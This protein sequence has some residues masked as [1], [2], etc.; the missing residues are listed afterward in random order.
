[1]IEA[2]ELESDRLVRRS[3]SDLEAEPAAEEEAGPGEAGV[4]LELPV[5]V[6]HWE[7]VMAHCAFAGIKYI[8]LISRVFGP[9]FKLRTEFFSID[10]WVALEP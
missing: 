4:E 2:S 8:P 9:S 6:E 1:M 7:L 5:A 10:L 3:F